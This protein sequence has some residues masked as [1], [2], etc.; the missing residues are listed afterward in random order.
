MCSNAYIELSNYCKAN[1]RDVYVCVL[2]YYTSKGLDVLWIIK[3]TL[4]GKVS[5]GW[6]MC[7]FNGKQIK[8]IYIAVHEHDMFIMFYSTL[9]FMFIASN[10]SYMIAKSGNVLSDYGV[11]TTYLCN[12]SPMSQFVAMAFASGFL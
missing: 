12:T 1:A 10:H 11:L 4:S 9:N 5:S 6:H 3:R 7:I 2:L 8:P